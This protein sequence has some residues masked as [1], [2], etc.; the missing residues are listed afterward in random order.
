MFNRCSGLL[1]AREL[2]QKNALASEEADFI[3]RNLAKMQLALGDA[4]LTAFGKYHWS[5]RER[6]RRLAAFASEELPPW[7]PEVQSHHA[8]GLAF[9]LHPR[10]V[11]KTVD[12]FALEHRRLTELAMQLWLWLE[13]RRLNQRFLSAS[14]YA[15]SDVDKCPETLAWRNYFLSL[16]TFGPK[17][18]LEAMSCRYPRERLF[19]ALALL[20]WDADVAA[21]PRLLRRLRQELQTDAPDWAGLVDVFKR[22]WPSYG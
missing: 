1:L 13:G 4:A 14:D 3:G 8:A 21:Q 6:H 22:I 15:L 20:L 7:L 11:S 19:H 10:R 17:A 5:V 2:L 9:K 12:E 16:R 18:T